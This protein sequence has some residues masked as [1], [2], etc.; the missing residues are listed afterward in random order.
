MVSPTFTRTN[1]NKKESSLT[2][3]VSSLSL[4]G[5]EYDASA[6]H[7]EEDDSEGTEITVLQPV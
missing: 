7:D 5:Y 2:F 1:I 3:A 4:V 6:N